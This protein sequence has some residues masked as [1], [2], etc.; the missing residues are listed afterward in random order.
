MDRN[1]ISTDRGAVEY[2]SDGGSS[3]R[4][5]RYA[6]LVIY[7]SLLTVF[8][9]VTLIIIGVV[10]QPLYSIYLKTLK[11]KYDANNNSL[12]DI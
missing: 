8:T 12:E 2:Y 7:P 6:T 4:I 1:I 10:S 3:L 5:V 11:E 9:G